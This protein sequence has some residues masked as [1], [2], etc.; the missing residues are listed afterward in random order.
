MSHA[1]AVTLTVDDII[2]LTGGHCP[3]PHLGTAISGANSITNAVGTEVTFLHHQGYIKYLPQCNAGAVLVSQTLYQKAHASFPPREGRG[4][5][6]VVVDDAHRAFVKLVHVLYPPETVEF[7]I[8]HPRAVIHPDANVHATATIGPGCVV[9]EGCTVEDHAVLT[10]NVV[11]HPNV[12][13]G[14]AS[15]LNG[16]VVCYANS[17]V[18]SRCIIHAGAVI[19]SDGFGFLEQE[20][21][22]FEKIPHVGTVH[23]GND[24]EIGANTTI[25]RAAVGTT[26]ISDGVK[27]DNLVHIAHGV[28]IG[29]NTAIAAQAGISGSAKLG[30][31]NRIAGQVGIVGHI[32]TADDVVVEAQ[33]GLSKTV[34]KAGVY[35]GSPAKDHRTALRIEASVRQL[36]DIVQQL[37]E[38]QKTVRELQEQQK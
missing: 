4:Y 16:N 17:V 38:L 34:E 8:Q 10:A 6:L 15:V 1:G 12:R 31:R 14:S 13:I 5:V 25:D 22:S 3:E 30:E 18:G 20:D 32:T 19:G 29:A 36:P 33:S 11:L 23:I 27:I 24:V 35:F 9:S 21:G 26:V 28:R 37:A 2:R 7:G